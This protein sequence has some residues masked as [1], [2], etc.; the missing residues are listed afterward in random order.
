[1]D[2]VDYESISVQEILES[3]DRGDLNITPWYQR[4]S[5]WTKPQKAYLINTLHE[6]MPV[7]SIYIR[8][9]IDIEKE[10]SIKEVVD[11]QQRVR[12][13]LEY[14]NNIFP[15]KHPNYKQSVLYSD[16][17]KTERIKFL[18][19]ALSVGY[20]ID[21]TDQDVIDIFGRINSVAKTLNPQEKRNS[22]FSGA[23][24][25]FCLKQAVDRLAFWRNYRIF[26]DND[27]ARMIEVQF[28]SDLVMN[29]RQG[30]L[31]FSGPRLTNYYKEYDEDFP[32]E[33]AMANRLDWLFS[34]L[35]DLHADVLKGSIFV[36]PQIL[37]SLLLVLDNMRQ[38][39]PST[40]KIE[41]CITELDSKVT[42]VKSGE[43]QDALPTEVFVAFITG[44]MHR[45]R[46]RRVR[47]RAIREL[48]Q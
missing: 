2:R 13:L 47:D 18:L 22:Q 35:L 8:H 25:Q 36:R 11:G 10:R 38:D 14:R 46:Y 1:M 15:A 42:A 5:V 28:I 23:Y 19:T 3:F 33:D 9:S 12:C 17:K 31:D 29:L 6:S 39:P 26:T 16:L 32:E 40:T 37:F 30:L 21:A 45:I 24:K 7:P 34:R 48:L 41:T 20:L 44:N 27:I 43:V 4:R